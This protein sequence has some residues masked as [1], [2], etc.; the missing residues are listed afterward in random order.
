[1]HHQKDPSAAAG[2][3]RI[4]RVHRRRPVR[5]VGQGVRRVVFGQQGKE[6]PRLVDAPHGMVGRRVPAEGEVTKS[7]EIE[8]GDGVVPFLRQSE[9]PG[10]H[11][12]E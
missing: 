2:R 11:Y 4:G 1:M 8:S 6:L 9:K 7:S 12:P 3:E 5:Q 10:L